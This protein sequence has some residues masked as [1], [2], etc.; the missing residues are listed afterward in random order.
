[1]LENESTHM[2]GLHIVIIN[3]IDGKVV[4]AQ[5]FDTCKSSSAFEL[6][7]EKDIPPGYIVVAACEDDCV[8]NLSEN[9]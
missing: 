2:R 6:F 1:M 4:F 7:T 9:G 5:A 8:L 3:P